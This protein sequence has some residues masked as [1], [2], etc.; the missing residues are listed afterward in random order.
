VTAHGAIKWKAHWRTRRWGRSCPELAEVRLR[1]LVTGI[2]WTK[3]IPTD[4]ETHSARSDRGWDD[5]LVIPG[6]TTVRSSELCPY[7]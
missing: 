1:F 5:P 2:S 7:P 3:Q 6:N 4:H